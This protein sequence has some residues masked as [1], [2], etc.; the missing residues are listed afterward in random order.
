MMWLIEAIFARTH[1]AEW[2]LALRLLVAVVLG[3]VIGWER[4]AKSRPAG[5][6]THMLTSL[7]AAVFSVVALELVHWAQR[8]GTSADPIRAIEAVTAG[9][10]FLAAGTI[11]Q[12]RG[13]VTG[14]TTG[15]SMWL[16][17]AIGVA[18]GTGLYSI[19]IYVAL[20]AFLILAGLQRL[21]QN[22]NPED[23]TKR[24][25]EKGGHVDS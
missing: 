6:K 14:L 2:D 22:I 24:P 5:L 12:S 8:N 4:E 9:V 16:A 1:I 15:A 19:A 18:T 11:I 23:G 21:S 10:A 3:G 13:K 25:A 17:G 7:A 20:L